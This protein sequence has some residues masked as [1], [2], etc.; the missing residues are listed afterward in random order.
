MYVVLNTEQIA[1][2]LYH[3]LVILDEK[4]SVLHA[5]LLGKPMLFQCSI[6]VFFTFAH[7]QFCNYHEAQE[8]ILQLYFERGID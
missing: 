3:L 5:K 4:R 7:A 2:C 1:K 8:A 6:H